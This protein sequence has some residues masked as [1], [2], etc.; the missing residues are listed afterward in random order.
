MSGVI[1]NELIDTVAA[2]ATIEADRLNRAEVGRLGT[3]DLA[4]AVLRPKVK[5]AAAARG[6]TGA[7]AVNFLTA[8]AV[9]TFG[10]RLALEAGR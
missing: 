6:L 9:V 7:E 8:G 2:I 1:T 5:A 3:A 10:A 4:V